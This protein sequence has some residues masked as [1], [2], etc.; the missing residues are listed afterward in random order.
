ML[1]LVMRLPLPNLTAAP[2]PVA[3]VSHR[4]L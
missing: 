1:P 3:L 4:A 2:G